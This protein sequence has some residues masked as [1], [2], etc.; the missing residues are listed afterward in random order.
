[1]CVCVVSPV[2]LCEPVDCIPPGSSGHGILQARILEWVAISKKEKPLVK[3]KLTFAVAGRT[4][5]R[6]TITAP[7]L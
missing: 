1:M 4:L 7:A 6:D 5:R 3:G 2:R